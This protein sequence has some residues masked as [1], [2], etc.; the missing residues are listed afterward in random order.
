MK[1]HKRIEIVVE[2]SDHVKISFENF[3]ILAKPTPE[4]S[5]VFYFKLDCGEAFEIEPRYHGGVRLYPSNGAR[6]ATQLQE[7]GNY[8]EIPALDLE[9]RPHFD[10][11]TASEEYGFPPHA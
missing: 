6:V 2:P 8:V 5:Q 3:S 9:I 10:G 7:G 11:K 4:G 1:T